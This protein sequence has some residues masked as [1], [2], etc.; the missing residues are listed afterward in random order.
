MCHSLCV[1]TDIIV[2]TFPNTYYFLLVDAIIRLKCQIVS[3]IIIIYF[4]LF[5]VTNQEM[6]VNISLNIEKNHC[7]KMSRYKSQL[8]K[9]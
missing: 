4:N 6:K 7:F 9:T 8:K 5:D 3:I 1:N 2:L